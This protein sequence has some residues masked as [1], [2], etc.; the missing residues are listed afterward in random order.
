MSKNSKSIEIFFLKEFLKE[1][2]LT[3]Y[4]NT[5]I[6]NY[7][8]LCFKLNYFMKHIPLSFKIKKKCLYEA[9]LIEFRILPHIEFIIRN[10]I[11][12]LGSKWSYTIICGELNYNLCKNI[13]QKISEN[14]TVIK[15]NH[16]NMT[17]QEYSDF[18]MT[19]KFW[20]L[21]HGEKILIYQE[22][23]LIFKDNIHDFMNY[24][25][26][27]APFFKTSNDT[28]N[29]VGNG[30][31]SLRT[32][33][34]MI[35]VINKCPIDQLE[36]GSST[37][38][39]MKLNKLVTPPE[40]VYF[41]KNLQQF[42]IGDVSDW[43]TAYKFSSESVFN[44]DS[45]GCHKIWNCNDK[46]KTHLLKN[47]NYHVYT[48]ASDIKYYLKFLKL[49][50]LF[51]E[52]KEKPNAFDIDLFFFC[53]LNNIE[54]INKLIALKHFSTIGLH[55]YIYHPKQITNFFPNVSFHTYLNNIYIYY[56]KSILP[57]Q[58]FVNNYI[59]NVSFE[60]FVNISI[61]K[62]YDYLNDN[63]DLLVL[64]YI[65]NLE[66]GLDLINKLIQYKKIQKDINISFCFNTNVKNLDQFSNIKKLIK[67]HFDFYAIYFCKEYGTDITPTMLMYDDIFKTRKFNHIIKLHTKSKESYEELTNYLLSCPLSKLITKVNIKSNCIGSCYKDMN[68][69]IFNK[70]LLS[71]NIE[72]V[73]KDYFFV[74][75]TIFYTTNV[76]F[77]KVLDFIKK[78]NY[79]AYLL[80][81][82]YENNSINK[83]YSP[84]H[85]LERLFG[86]IKL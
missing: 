48:P 61:D 40:D 51:N 14:I 85:F 77:S 6:N 9:V 5:D 21:I 54:F 75:G 66:K 29:C 86:I 43:D 13:S 67:Y 31:L 74:A 55:G 73:Y 53:I 49:P 4:E 18:L 15:L 22:D 58:N 3:S 8:R 64:V 81:N 24:D 80:N 34:K 57:I 84:I 50:E 41:S 56:N 38:E 7:R 26:I 71:V 17:Q 25:F 10:A 82:L 27:G 36:L 52:T 70:D 12:K 76:V 79:K 16:I 44:P 83:N 59:Y 30:G 37:K 45:F 47:F 35:E 65:G 2:N 68:Q 28:P 11:N 62:K 19:K 33:T 60:Y 23:S 20:D 63:Y 46:W 42:S 69:D 1:N 72:K 32:K 39:Y 78:N